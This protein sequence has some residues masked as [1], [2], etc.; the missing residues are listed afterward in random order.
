MTDSH[1]GL[2]GHVHEGSAIV[3]VQ[4]GL[5]AG[6]IGGRS[7]SP[8]DARQAVIH[9][10]VQVPAPLHVIGDEQV[11]VSVLV[12]IEE[13]RRG[14]PPIPVPGHSGLFRNVLESAATQ[15]AIQTV[16]TDCR[17]EDVRQ[18][19]RIHVSQGDTHPVDHLIQAGT[20]GGVCESAVAPVQ[21]EGG[22]DRPLRRS[23]PGPAGRIDEQQVRIAVS[24]KV[25][26]CHAAAHGLRQKALAPGATEMDEI[27]AGHGRHI[28][29]RQGRWRRHVAFTE[30]RRGLQPG[31][32]HRLRDG[33]VSQYPPA[34]RG[35]GADGQDDYCGP[36]QG[37]TYDGVVLDQLIRLI[38]CRRARFA[39]DHGISLA[40]HRA[41]IPAGGAVIP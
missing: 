27:D 33:T 3:A 34:R 7:V 31:L 4:E 21:V 28:G 22:G 24:V 30:G 1:A 40:A 13:C 32:V 23:R 20:D 18:A 26:E 41:A 19:V 39:R 2:P 15:I 17:D 37:R 11:Q 36:A 38:G 9:F 8:S 29:E 5:G 12:E 10:E 35:D 16:V 14:A 6:K 25:V